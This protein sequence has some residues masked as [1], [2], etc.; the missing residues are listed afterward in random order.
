[1]FSCKSFCQ[2]SNIYKESKVSIL[3]V[4][5]SLQDLLKR[6]LFE[7]WFEWRVESN[8]SFFEVRS[9][10]E[11]FSIWAQ[12]ST[13]VSIALAVSLASGSESQAS[14]ISRVKSLVDSRCAHAG[15][16]FGRCFFDTTTER[17]TSFDGWSLTKWP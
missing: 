2:F 12:L 13:L 7:Y 16:T 4:W 5:N 8:Q 9:P 10:R 1:M 3:A 17:I 15:R 6:I 14:S 11:I